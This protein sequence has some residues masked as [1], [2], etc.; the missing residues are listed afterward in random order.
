MA[1]KNLRWVWKD[2]LVDKVIVLKYEDLSVI[3]STHFKSQAQHIDNTYNY[4][5]KW[6]VRQK[7]S[8][9]LAGQVSWPNQ[10]VL[11]SVKDPDSVDNSRMR[12]PTIDM[13][14][15]YMHIHV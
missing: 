9:E 3:P 8:L 12:H 10:W 11:G 4:S 6:R 1:T 7:E 5:L 15:P 13:G 2:D 14:P